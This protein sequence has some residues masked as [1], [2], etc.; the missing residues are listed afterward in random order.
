MFVGVPRIR[1]CSLAALTISLLCA[2][3]CQFPDYDRLLLTP[4]G[5]SGVA[6]AAG[7]PANGGLSGAAATSTGGESP[8]VLDGG[9]AGHGGG[10]GGADGLAGQGG[11]PGAGNL[12]F[13]DDFENGS[14]AWSP[15]TPI[16]WS[17]GTETDT[18][19]VYEQDALSNDTRISTAGDIA[20]TDQAVEVRVKVFD[21]GGDQS[22]AFA[23]VYARY[24][25]LENHYYAALRADGRLAIKARI[26]GSDRTL[27]SSV[28]PKL[29][30]GVWYTVRLEARGTLIQLFL[31]GVLW[32]SVPT[33]LDQ[34]IP[35]GAIGVGT[36]DAQAVF[37]DVRVTTPE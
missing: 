33:Q 27:G 21:F 20:W 37:D 31:D 11:Q 2:A 23:A 10:A 29:T 1:R 25:D 4:G 12:L 26:D 32:D 34:S 6:G 36:S 18:N 13:A 17:I 35:A 28:D 30:T 19:Q 22:E 7:N 8:T 16:D 9:A 3:S 24:Q 14:S 5:N 15:T